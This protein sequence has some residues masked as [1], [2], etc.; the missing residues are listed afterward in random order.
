MAHCSTCGG[1][2]FTYTERYEPCSSCGGSGTGSHTDTP[3]MVCKGS[4]HS[5]VKATETCWQCHGTGQ[6]HST[7]DA[8]SNRSN[9]TSKSTEKPSTSS[10]STSSSS[11][12]PSI[13][14]FI[15]LVFGGYAVYVTQQGGEALPQQLVISG[16]IGFIIAFVVLYI[17]YLLL[18]AVIAIV[19]IVAVIGF[20]FIVAILVGNA[21]EI[22]LA[23][24]GYRG[25]V[26]TLSW[27]TQ[28]IESL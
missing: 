11:E 8:T 27:L 3:C 21:M 22:E 19:K 25:L 16:V 17:L 13:I 14:G 7:D 28:A 1:H 26:Q 24:Q 6:I 9:D 4:G 18:K 15:S 12:A 5:N 2:G 20:W 10:S 23:Q